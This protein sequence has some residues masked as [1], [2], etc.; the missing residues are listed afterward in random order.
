MKWRY[1][2]AHDGSMAR[3]LSIL[4]VNQMVWPGMGAELAFE[5]YS[6]KAKFDDGVKCY[7]PSRC[8][9]V[10]RYYDLVTLSWAGWICFPLALFLLYVDGLVGVR[11][12]KIPAIVFGV[13]VNG[14]DLS[15]LLLFERA[16]GGICKAF[17]ECEHGSG[18]KKEISKHCIY[19]VHISEAAMLSSCNIRWLCSQ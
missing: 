1:N 13:V 14:I 11:G 4:Q 18:A 12:S 6:Q 10:A 19:I 5:L 17:L 16:S 15:L 9:G 7:F 2:A 8:F 3:L